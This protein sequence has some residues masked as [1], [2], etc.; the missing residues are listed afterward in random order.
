MKSPTLLC[1]TFSVMLIF[2]SEPLFAELRSIEDSVVQSFEAVNAGTT[3]CPFEQ[4]CES[5]QTCTVEISLR[6]ALA[7]KLLSLTS[8]HG[9]GTKDELAEMIGEYTATAD[10]FLTCFTADDGPVCSFSYNV[11]TNRLASMAVCE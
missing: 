8:R 5:G 2:Q 9:K 3:E 10:E 11:T 4:G 1:A 7:A 6:G